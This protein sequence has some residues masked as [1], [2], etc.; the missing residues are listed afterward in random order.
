SVPSNFTVAIR[1]CFPSMCVFN[2]WRR[3][4]QRQY[5]RHVSGEQ[6]RVPTHRAGHKTIRKEQHGEPSP[7]EKSSNTASHGGPSVC[8][9]QPSRGATRLT[10]NRKGKTVR[11]RE[12]DGCRQEALTIKMAREHAA[13]PRRNTGGEDYRE[14]QEAAQAHKRNKHQS[15]EKHR[16]GPRPGRRLHTSPHTLT[17]SQC[18]QSAGERIRLSTQQT[19]TPPAATHHGREE[20]TQRRHRLQFNPTAN[21]IRPQPRSQHTAQKERAITTEP[22]TQKRFLIH[23]RRAASLHAVT[24]CSTSS[25]QL[26]RPS[27]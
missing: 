19:H 16:H 10:P 22:H 11:E 7:T 1:A 15:R 27:L 4:R 5:I 13:T 14:R 3:Q 23:P 12:M 6:G 8:A 18:R 26:I 24:E 2:R 25:I 9:G 20:E 21:G 17:P